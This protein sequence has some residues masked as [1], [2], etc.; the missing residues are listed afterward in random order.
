MSHRSANKQVTVLHG[1]Y[2]RARRVWQVPVNPASDV[3]RL[4]ESYDASKYDFY[5]PED[6]LALARELEHPT[7]DENGNKPD[8]SP[9]DAAIVT[10]AAF[11]GL[12]LGEILGLRVRDVDFP[13]TA[14][15]SSS[16]PTTSKG[17]GRPRA[18]R[19]AASRWCPRSRTSSPAPSAATTSPNPTTS[20]SRTRSA[21]PSTAPRSDAA[22]R[23]HRSGQ[24]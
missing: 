11:A 19:P 12:R 8:D 6:V 23:P 24:D 3:E 20:C 10:V 13:P 16:P 18:A 15:A 9:Q 21:S 14:S 17:S 2:E 7:A 1:I 4:S 22:T 5:E